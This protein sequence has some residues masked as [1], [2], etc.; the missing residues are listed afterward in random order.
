MGFFRKAPQ[1]PTPNENLSTVSPSHQ[2]TWYDQ[3]GDKQRNTCNCDT[4]KDHV[5]PK[6]TK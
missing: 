6:E 5:T 1:H 3:N 4:G 2:H